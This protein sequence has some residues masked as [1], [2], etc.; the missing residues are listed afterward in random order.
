MNDPFFA[1]RLLRRYGSFGAVGL[2][3]LV[4]GGLSWCLWVLI[5]WIAFA[6]GAMVGA[7]IFI[8]ARSY[9]ELVSM[10]FERLN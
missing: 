9:V 5:G 2:A 10:I 8:I 3:L 7:L 6:L 1:I 4:T